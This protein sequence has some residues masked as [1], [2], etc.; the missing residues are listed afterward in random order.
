MRR[1]SIIEKHFDIR[2]TAMIVRMKV[3]KKVTAM[4]RM[5]IAATS[6]D[7]LDNCNECFFFGENVLANSSIN[8]K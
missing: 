1:R 4:M 8:K 6:V 5:K 3:V 7:R 2:R